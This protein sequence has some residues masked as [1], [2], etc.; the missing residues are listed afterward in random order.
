MVMI[1]Q[2][3]HQVLNQITVKTLLHQVWF[4]LL[5]SISVRRFSQLLVKVF[6]RNRISIFNLSIP[7]IFIHGL[8]SEERRVGRECRRRPPPARQ[9]ESS[10]VEGQDGPR[11][12][13][14]R[15][16]TDSLP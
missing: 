14:W 10:H 8:R 11:E 9:K 4:G 6:F 1:S 13:D 15:I 16:V 5:T 3:L 7:V 12:R 2:L